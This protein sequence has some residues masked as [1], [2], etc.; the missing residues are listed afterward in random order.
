MRGCLGTI[1]AT[2][3]DDRIHFHSSPLHITR[4]A[5]PTWD[6]WSGLLHLPHAELGPHAD[7]GLYTGHTSVC[8]AQLGT[9]TQNWVGTKTN[10]N[11]NHN[12]VG[13]ATRNWRGDAELGGHWISH[14]ILDYH[15]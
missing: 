3:A 14:A 13:A 8:D 11:R 12:W 15:S 6:V 7:V 9:M 5:R 1:N 4:D 2:R 10:M